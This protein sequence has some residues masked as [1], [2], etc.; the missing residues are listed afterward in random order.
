MVAGR[1]SAGETSASQSQW[2]E[3]AREVIAFHFNPVLGFAVGVCT[4]VT[5][6]CT[7]LF[8][9]LR[10]YRSWRAAQIVA[11]RFQ[12]HSSTFEKLSVELLGHVILEPRPTPC[13]RVTLKWRQACSIQVYCQELHILQILAQ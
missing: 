8:N 13:I 2:S 7:H 3:T 10:D 9:F 4:C 12:A 1:V 6:C 5:L 11:R